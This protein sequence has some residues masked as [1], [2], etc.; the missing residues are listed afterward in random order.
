[1]NRTTVAVDLAKNRFELAIADSQCRIFQHERLTRT[2]FV[3]FFSNYPTSLI[4]MEACG[5]AHHWA[6]TFRDQGH[7]VRLLPAHYVKA[8]VRR[9]KT[10]AADAEAL[11]EASRCAEIRPV[12][13]KSV[14]QQAIQQLHRLRSQWI[15]TR[16]ARINQLR[17]AL[18]E[19]GIFIPVGAK[20]AVTAI[21]E[22]LEE[23]GNGLPD[24]LRPFVLEVLQEIAQLEERNVRIDLT[25]RELTGEDAVVQ[26]LLKIPGIGL[27]TASALRAII[28]DA[29]RFPSGRH[30]ASWLGLTA[31]E[32]SSGERRCLG[33][34]SKRGDVYLRTLLIHAARSALLAAGR[35]ARAD[36]PL[37]RVQTWVLET[38]RRRGHNK[39][40]VAL[41]NKLARIVWA[42]WAHDRA[43]NGNWNCAV[44]H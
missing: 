21:R 26:R 28:V 5:S 41:A 43:F 25:L 44:M 31:R 16:T 17:A 33:G 32:H 22:A 7:E 15:R 39:A 40:A 11:I 18:R 35:A 8:Y 13:V 4:V 1:M 14:E 23:A 3:R 20:R 2:R 34:I 6:R 38:E 29:R 9:N 42:T 30:L 19:F 24:V 10:D 12:P 37:T 36:R 27:L